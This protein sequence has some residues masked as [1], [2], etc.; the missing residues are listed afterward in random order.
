MFYLDYGMAIAITII[1][2]FLALFCMSFFIEIK[3]SRKTAREKELEKKCPHCKVFL[4]EETKL[5]RSE[6]GEEIIEDVCGTYCDAQIQRWRDDYYQIIRTCDKCG[7]SDVQ[8][9]QERR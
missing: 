6:E 5:I 3:D 4:K 8:E 9:K 7:Y 2:L 1:V